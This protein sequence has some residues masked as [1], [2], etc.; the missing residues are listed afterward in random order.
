V[1]RGWLHAW[2][3]RRAVSAAGAMKSWARR[4]APRA[5]L[6]GDRTTAA[7]RVWHDMLAKGCRAYRVCE[8]VPRRRRLPT[9]LGEQRAAAVAPNVLDRTFQAPAPTANGLPITYVWTAG[10]WLYAAERRHCQSDI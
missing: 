9:D 6:R 3:T 7:R 8:R 2:L 1:S 10:G 4:F 5:S